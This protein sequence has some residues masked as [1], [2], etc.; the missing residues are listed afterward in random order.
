LIALARTIALLTA[1]A[2]VVFANA[3]GPDG[4]YAGVPGESTCAAC[5]VGSSGSGSVSVSF[6]NGLTYMPGVKQTLTVTVSDSAQ[7]RWGFQLTA[8]QSSNSK[9]QAGTFT[10]GGDGYTQLV[11]VNT[12]LTTESYS[13]CPSSTYPLVYIEQTSKGTQAGKTG[14]GSF[15]F[16]WTPPAADFGSVVVYVAGNAAN[17]NGTESGDHIYT[18]RYTLT[19]A[20]AAPKPSIAQAGVVNGASYRPGIAAGSWITIQ[21]ANLSNTGART[22][23]ADEI[24]NGA[25]PTQLDGVSVTV[26]GKPAFVEYIGPTQINA[27]APSDAGIGE[28]SVV[29]T[30]NGVASDAAATQI[31]ST[32]PAFFLW[33][34]KYAVATRQDY[35]YIGPPSLFPGATTPAK[36]GDVVILWGTGFG[37]TVP[38][39]PAGVQVSGAAYLANAPAVNVGGFSAQVVGAAL[40][41]GAAGLYQIAIVLPD[42]LPDGDLEVVALADGE[43]SPSGVFITIQK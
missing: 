35:S 31:L 19:P 33:N 16:T 4:T 20:A 21:G 34:G 17:N 1:A 28:A 7:R 18:N 29:V 8:R 41:P 32:S 26:N 10:I 38:A 3:S 39:Q 2:A 9:S 6:P 37:P 15:T 23:R 25:L 43:P 14:S 13:G 30:V 27:Q 24:V 36:P 12:A 22:W 5:H 11:C 40:A 42:S